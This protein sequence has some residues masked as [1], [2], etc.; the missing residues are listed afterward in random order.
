MHPSFMMYNVV[1]KWREVKRL[2][3][4]EGFQV[5]KERGRTRGKGGHM[6]FEKNGVRTMLPTGSGELKPATMKS[7]LEAIEEARDA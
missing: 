1:M 2:L 6:L 4:R 7:I 5:V 3:Q